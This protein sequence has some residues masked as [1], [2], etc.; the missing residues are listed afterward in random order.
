VRELTTYVINGVFGLLPVTAFLAV[1]AHSDTFKLIRFRLILLLILAGA[2]AALVSYAIGAG[3]TQ[4][5]GID[6]DR[7]TRFDGPIIEESLKALIVVFLIRTN[8]V[9]FVLDAAIAGFAIGTGFAL[10][11]NYFYLQV[12]GA[13]HPA[14]WVVRGFGT[15]IMHG[16]ATALFAV[17]AHL[18]T[19]QTAKGSLLRFAPGFF[20]AAA[21]HVVFNQFLEYPVSS[22]IAMLMG[23]AAIL[24]LVFQRDRKSIEHWLEVDF[25][26]H[27]KLLD[28]IRSGAFGE[29]DLGRILDVLHRRF[30]ATEIAE[31]VQY[32]ELHTE[33]ILFAEA[34]LEA[35]DRGERVEIADIVVKK[36]EHFH[37]IEEDI[38]HAV[39]VALGRHLHFSRHEFFELYM[40]DREAELKQAHSV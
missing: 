14:V 37:E 20:A 23:L 29:H 11:E 38:G 16:G 26:E 1:L 36:L 31:I 21:L 33:L 25:E 18:M 28:E 8:R 35:R 9:G 5:F 4:R 17:L 40:L 12:I 10:L 7:F 19:P 15:A 6:Y 3:V 39:R 30:D 22:A 13:H 32:V 24:G 2:G 27:R 34:I